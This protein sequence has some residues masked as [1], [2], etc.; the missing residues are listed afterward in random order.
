MANLLVVEDDEN[1]CQ[2]VQDWLIFEKYTVEVATS[3]PDALEQ[4]SMNVFDLIVLDWFL[5]D[6]NGIDVLRRYRAAGGRT[7]VLMLTG[8]DSND[9][10]Q[11]GL[12]A[13]ADGYIKKPFKL[14]EL[15]AQIKSTL[16]LNT[17]RKI[18]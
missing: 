4:L 13:G 11:A 15:S 12:D 2:T 17:E 14:Q 6:I 10:R 7:P 3:G 18:T 8:Q 9:A 16:T 1:L 5:P